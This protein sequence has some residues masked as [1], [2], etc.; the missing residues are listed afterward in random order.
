MITAA[1]AACRVRQLLALLCLGMAVLLHPGTAAAQSCSTTASPTVA[2]GSIDVLSGSNIP[3]SSSITVQCN[4][5]LLSIGSANFKVCLS[6]GGASGTTPRTMASGANSL[7]YNLYSDSAHTQ[8]W[9]SVFSGSP[10][11]VVDIPLTASSLLLG[12]TA[13]TT[14]PIYGYLQASQN[15]TAPAGPYTQNLTGGQVVLTYNYTYALGTPGTPASCASGSGTSVSGTFGFSPT[16]TVSNSCQVSTSNVNFG[17]ATSLG[18]VLH[19][20]GSVSVTCTMSDNYTITLGTGSTSGASLTDRR[21]QGP[22]GNVAHYELY[23]SSSY[24]TVWGDGVTGGTGN[25]TGVG[26]ATQQTY[27][28][29]GQVQSQNTPAVGSYTDA[30]IVTVN[31]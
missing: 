14:V 4:L 1:V 9:G 15:T 20:N 2:F 26:T 13:S 10:T 18:G 19:A 21:M 8:I 31:Y 5:G 29:Y 22:G 30:V 28:V 11:G 24:G 12:G 3:T 27:T 16:A 17:S 25:V 23:T 6:I 7:N